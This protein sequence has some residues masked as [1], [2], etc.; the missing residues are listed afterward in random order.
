VLIASEWARQPTDKVWLLSGREGNRIV[1]NVAGTVTVHAVDVR[2]RYA[3]PYIS[4]R[5]HDED[6]L[7]PVISAA[8]R[9]LSLEAEKL[10]ASRI[11]LFENRGVHEQL[12]ARLCHAVVPKEV[13]CPL[14]LNLSP[15]SDATILGAV[16]SK[17]YTETEAIAEKHLPT[18]VQLLTQDNSRIVDRDL[19]FTLFMSLADTAEALS[20]VARKSRMLN[21]HQF[22]ALIKRILATPGTGNEAVSILAKVNRLTQE[23]R[24]ELRTKVFREASLSTIANQAGAL[25]VS[26]AEV[27]ELA[28][29]MRA[30]QQLPPD[31]AVLVLDKFGERLP[32]EAQREAIMAIVNAKASL[33][34]TALQHVNFSNQWREKLLEKVLSEATYEDFD[35]AHLSREMLE[36]LLTPTE[37]RSLI[38]TV[39]KRSEGSTK[40]LDL[41]VRVLPIRAMTLVERKTIL[42]ALLFESS[43][44][45]LE[46]VS[47]Y[48]YYLDDQDVNE[49]TYD[50]SKT[51]TPD[52]CLHLSH[53]NKN[54][55]VDYFSEAQLRIFRDC[56]Q[57]K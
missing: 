10:R 32:V 33:A 11:A 13:T 12:L 38:A 7:A 56:A 16:W 54:R 37:M 57:S 15:Q 40:W 17:Y 36:D 47:D 29:R 23:Q 41:A 26:D 45:A 25:R 28:P 39:I 20:A 44:S 3:E 46:F 49:V 24:Q 35:G 48:R 18:L 50:Y 2:Y 8:N 31:V 30:P 51:I 53:R 21:E 9:I 5:N 6:L 22:D 27:A 52:F 19:V 34:L 1:R 43:K 4:G 42:N 14:R 55:K